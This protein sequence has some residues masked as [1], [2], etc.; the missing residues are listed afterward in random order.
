MPYY[1]CICENC[2]SSDVIN[3]ENDL[4]CDAKD[5]IIKRK[6]G[7]RHCIKYTPIK[8][9]KDIFPKIFLE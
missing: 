1:I 3:E 5:K 8:K 2:I 6:Q 7:V 4:Y 9:K